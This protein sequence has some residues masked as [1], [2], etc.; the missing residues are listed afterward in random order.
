MAY[1]ACT[2][3]RDAKGNPGKMELRLPGDARGM[4]ALAERMIAAAET[5]CRYTERKNDQTEEE[6]T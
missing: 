4:R 1:I 6:T 2:F 3:T 5:A